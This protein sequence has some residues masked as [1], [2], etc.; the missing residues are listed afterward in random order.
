M[1]WRRFLLTAWVVVCGSLWTGRA[2]A[3]PLP[4]AWCGQDEVATD[5]P[6]V[7]G[8]D[9]VHVVYAYPGDRPDRF[10]EVVDAI[11]R[12]LAGV[13]TWWQAQ[14]PVRTPRFDLGSFAGCT[15]EFG[16]L[17]VS[18]TPLGP[19][20]IDWNAPH[21]GGDLSNVLA[22]A[23]FDDQT[24]KYLVYYDAPG[25]EH[26]CGTSL[27]TATGGGATNGS[28]VFLG[29]ERCGLDAFGSGNGNTALTAAHE[30]LHNLNGRSGTLGGPH[31]CEDDHAHYCDSPVDI[32]QPTP[33]SPSLSD[34]VLDDG[35]DDY[36]AHA[37]SWWDIQ[38][39]AWLR[40]L[41]HPA[42]VVSVTVRGSPG[43]EV[44]IGPLAKDCT[45]VCALR[46]DGGT[47]V[48]IH[49]IAA[50]GSRLIRWSG[51]CSGTSDICTVTAG[52]DDTN[53]TASFGRALTVTA[54]TRGAGS[55]SK[56]HE[57]ACRGGCQWDLAPRAQFEITAH[58]DRGAQFIGWHGLCDGTERTCTINLKGAHNL[59]V[60]ATFHR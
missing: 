3:A 8:E 54:R 13:D 48:Q 4:D 30:L 22:S 24:K 33:R 7:V 40:H 59:T 52:G 23:G 19:T 10:R 6:D 44:L 43:G 32:L 18:S 12:D 11:V 17:D 41:E 31:L 60:T 14:D 15:S 1:I 58:P 16:A 39:S 51:A 45:T 35:R 29:A 36:Y 57:P 37:G 46:Y 5:R 20:T 55:I 9:Q 53:V 27:G 50:Q 21:Y 42:G 28:Y 34:A 56:R 49:Q 47:R 26:V 2:I 38:D 25:P